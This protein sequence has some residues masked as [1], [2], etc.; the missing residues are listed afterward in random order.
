MKNLF[1]KYELCGLLRYLQNEGKTELEAELKAL[2][3]DI[4]Q[5]IVLLTHFK[6]DRDID[7]LVYRIAFT[8]LPGLYY[9]ERLIEK[10]KEHP[11]Q[12]YIYESDPVLEDFSYGEAA[13]CASSVVAGIIEMAVGISGFKCQVLAY[14]CPDGESGR[15][16]VYSIDVEL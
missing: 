2:G 11:R 13:F 9:A 10:G 1:L 4:A 8:L 3:G 16:I 12:F 6:R 15:K 7:S 5:R 14:N